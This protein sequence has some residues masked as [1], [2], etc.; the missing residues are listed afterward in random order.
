MTTS[1]SN[2]HPSTPPVEGIG[3][4]PA[5]GFA[6]DPYDEDNHDEAQLRGLTHQQLTHQ[7]N[8][9]SW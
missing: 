1:L 4:Y 2:H 8:W 7:L 9:L 3:E 6:E 5:D